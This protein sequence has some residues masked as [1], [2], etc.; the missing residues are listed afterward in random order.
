M[1]IQKNLFYLIDSNK[2]SGFIEI[3]K[4]KGSDIPK[5]G[6]QRWPTDD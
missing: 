5:S 6:A 2:T 1:V 3:E 4:M